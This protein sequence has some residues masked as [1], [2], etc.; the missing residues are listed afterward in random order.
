[1][2]ETA[3]IVKSRSDFFPG[4]GFRSQVSGSRF[5]VS[6]LICCVAFVI[7]FRTLMHDLLQTLMRCTRSFIRNWFIRNQ[8]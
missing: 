4:F 5:R 7:A 1:M 8:H 3:K 2:I 6:G